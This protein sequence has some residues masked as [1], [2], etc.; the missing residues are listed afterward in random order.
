MSPSPRILEDRQGS[1]RSGGGYGV[2]EAGERAPQQAR[3]V[4][5]RVADPLADLALAQVVHEA[6]Q[7]VQEAACLVI[8]ILETKD[9]EFVNEAAE[10]GSSPI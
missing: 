5:L 1:G 10:R 8:A 4:H 2:L 3:D 9:A 7:I 6:R